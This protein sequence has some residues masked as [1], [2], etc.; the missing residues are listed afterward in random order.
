MTCIGFYVDYLVPSSDPNYK[1]EVKRKKFDYQEQKEYKQFLK[2]NKE[3]VRGH[4]ERC[5]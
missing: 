4:G 2:D 1:Y 3:F 5:S